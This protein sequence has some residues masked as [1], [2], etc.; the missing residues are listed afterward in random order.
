MSLNQG[1][2]IG[3]DDM[4]KI[5][6]KSHEWQTLVTKNERGF[7][8]D[9][10]VGKHFLKVLSLCKW[11]GIVYSRGFSVMSQVSAVTN[12]SGVNSD[13]RNRLLFCI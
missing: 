10:Q 3:E 6:E 5:L 13:W 7:V 11:Y 1:T 8:L 4:E 9:A 12:S 2:A